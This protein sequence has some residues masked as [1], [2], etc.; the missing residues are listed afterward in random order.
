MAE[1][2]FATRIEVGGG[3]PNMLERIRRFEFGEDISEDHM[4]K[5]VQSKVC[6]DED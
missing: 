6:K 3:S 4:E 2:I 1:S 5:C